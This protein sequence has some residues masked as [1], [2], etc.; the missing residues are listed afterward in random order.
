[1]GGSEVVARYLFSIGLRDRRGTVGSVPEA[2][3]S[4]IRRPARVFQIP[5]AGTVAVRR[6]MASSPSF[7]RMAV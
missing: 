7:R 5:P 1:M 6:T 3:I 2:V 4:Y